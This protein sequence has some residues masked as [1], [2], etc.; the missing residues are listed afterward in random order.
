MFGWLGTNGGN[1]RAVDSA[2]ELG[3]LGVGGEVSAW[4][5]VSAGVVSA[6]QSDQEQD[7][8][9]CQHQGN[10]LLSLLGR[11]ICVILFSLSPAFAI[12]WL[13]WERHD[14]R[15][16]IEGWKGPLESLFYKIMMI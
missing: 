9:D 5:L 11:R 4:R 3:D 10:R 15:L 1:F 16:Q 8:S 12:V 6:V 14:V 7:C 13:F 2:G